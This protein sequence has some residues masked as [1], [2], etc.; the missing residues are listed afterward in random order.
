MFDQTN[1]IVRAFRM[2]RDRFKESD[3]I[4]LRLRLIADR[5]NKQYSDAT[6]SEVA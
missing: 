3:Y 5:A 4:T 6:C 1:V 2:A